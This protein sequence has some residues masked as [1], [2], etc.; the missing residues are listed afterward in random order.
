VKRSPSFVKWLVRSH[1]D[2]TGAL[3]S[4][5]RIR[6]AILGNASG[7]RLK[8]VHSESVT[9]AFSSVISWVLSERFCVSMSVAMIGGCFDDAYQER[10]G[11]ARALARAFGASRR[12]PIMS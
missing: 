10:E 1:Y 4:T 5:A 7:T 8:L 2:V 9:V 11:D 6:S 3:T 12:E